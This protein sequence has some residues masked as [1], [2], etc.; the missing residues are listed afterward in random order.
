MTEDPIDRTSRA[1]EGT[2][3]WYKC[4][5]RLRLLHGKQVG[6][7]FRDPLPIPG[8]AIIR[9]RSILTSFKNYIKERSNIYYV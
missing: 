9:E 7:V 5:G 1:L 3:N 6:P 2:C 4:K 8:L